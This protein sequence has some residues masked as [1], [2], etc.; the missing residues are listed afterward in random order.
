MALLSSNFVS[1]E[2][3]AKYMTL[4]EAIIAKPA[5]PSPLA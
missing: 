4:A 1:Q 2:S 3:I 5:A